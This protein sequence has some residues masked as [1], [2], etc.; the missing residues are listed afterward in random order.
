M[1]A[2]VWLEVAVKDQRSFR[3]DFVE[4]LLHAN[5]RD[6]FLDTYTF[7]PYQGRLDDMRT[8]AVPFQLLPFAKP[9]D[10]TGKLADSA[11]QAVIKK[12]GERYGL[13]NAGDQ[14]GDAVLTLPAGKATV[15]D[16]SNGVH[17][18]LL[19]ARNQAGEAEVKIH[20]APWSLK[21]LEIQ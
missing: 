14:P 21:T 12:Y 5:A 17:Q 19:T 6:F 10:Y 13:M 8:F 1:A 16:L 7:W 18:T 11:K 2:A 15:I 9:E 20:L 3:R 4:G